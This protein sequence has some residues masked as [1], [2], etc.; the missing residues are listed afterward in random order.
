M[1]SVHLFGGNGDG[2]DV[3]DGDTG[4]DQAFR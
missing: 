3:L 2:N 1:P 4:N